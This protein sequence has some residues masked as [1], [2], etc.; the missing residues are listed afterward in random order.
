MGCWR[1]GMGGVLFKSVG[2]RGHIGVSGDIC[3]VWKG[4]VFELE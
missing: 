3:D 4:Q 2:G 1:E